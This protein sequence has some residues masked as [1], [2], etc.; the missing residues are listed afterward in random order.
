MGS[1]SDY[2]IS[3][4][5]GSWVLGEDLPDG[6]EYE[7]NRKNRQLHKKTRWMSRKK[8]PR[9]VN[10]KVIGLARELVSVKEEIKK[11]KEKELKIKQ[12]LLGD[13]NF[14]EW[15]QVTTQGEEENDYI[16]EY[17]FNRPKPGLKRE[18]TLRFIRK[19]FGKEAAVLVEENCSFANNGIK[20]IYVRP[21]KKDENDNLET[22]N[23]EEPGIDSPFDIDV[24][25]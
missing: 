6:D 24:P 10:D 16:V 22:V 14:G 25:F 18:A 4:G 23:L 7:A 9:S 8:R 1:D 12:L 13:L 19:K 3:I 17:T 20:T 5:L 2:L 11:L 15:V 21:F